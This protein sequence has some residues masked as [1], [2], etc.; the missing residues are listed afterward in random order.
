MTIT[1]ILSLIAVTAIFSIYT[2]WSVKVFGSIS[3]ISEGYYK[4][5]EK[6]GDNK[7]IY[8]TAWCAMM[9][10]FCA[11]PLH[12]VTQGCWYNNLTLPTCAGLLIV[13]VVPQYKHYGY[14][15]WHFGGALV[16]MVSAILIT[17][18][19]GFALETLAILITCTLANFIT[20]EK[21]PLLWV[22]YTAILS[23]LIFMW[24]KV[25]SI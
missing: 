21:D 17:A 25:W 10:L 19:G 3:S 6:Y 13:G 7:G 16:S 4:L 9:A 22:E 20:K 1:A 15:E 18:F 11:V 12:E 14:K 2:L 8:F 23:L 24:T 5:T